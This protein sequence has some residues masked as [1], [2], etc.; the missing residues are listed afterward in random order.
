MFAHGLDE[1]IPVK[2]FYDGVEHIHDL[3][4]ALGK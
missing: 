1:R 3:A 2:S 4:V